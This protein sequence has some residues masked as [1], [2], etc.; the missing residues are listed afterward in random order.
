MCVILSLSKYAGEEEKRKSDGEKCEGETGRWGEK[1][2]LRYLVGSQQ[3][4]TNKKTFLPL[5]H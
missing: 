3:K 5:R 4:M 1:K 2:S